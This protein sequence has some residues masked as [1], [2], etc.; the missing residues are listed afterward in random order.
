MVFISLTATIP[1]NRTIQ[2][3]R[4]SCSL[5]EWLPCSLR[6]SMRRCIPQRSQTLPTSQTRPTPQPKS[7][8][9]RWPFCGCW[10]SNWAV[11]SP[12]SSS[13]GPPKFM[14]FAAYLVSQELLM[15]DSKCSC[16]NLFLVHVFTGNCWAAH[17]GKV[18]PGAHNGWLRDGPFATFNG[19]KCCFGTHPQ[20]IG[21]WRMGKCTWRV[22]RVLVCL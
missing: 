7:E 15:G 3:P 17:S 1:P 18:S 22:S 11:L 4:S 8:T 12:C 14:R 5:L 21:C 6:Q 9:W 2:S 13:E 19:G 20:N 16:S 10:S